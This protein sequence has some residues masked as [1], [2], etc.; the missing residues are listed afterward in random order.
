MDAPPGYRRHRSSSRR[1]HL[2]TGQFKKTVFILVFALAGSVALSLTLA[3]RYRIPPGLWRGNEDIRS[4]FPDIPLSGSLEMEPV[5][6]VL[7]A[8]EFGP[9]ADLFRR[10]QDD[11]RQKLR[12]LLGRPSSDPS[13]GVRSVRREKFN[14]IRRETLV[15]TQE[16]GLEVPAFLHRRDD[17]VVRPALLVIPGHSWGIVATSGIVDDY[18]NGN[19]LRLAAAGY[20]TLTME[21]RGFGY[22]QYFGVSDPPLT[23]STYTPLNLMRGKTSLGVT[24]QDQT[25]GLIYLASRSDV[26]RDQL[27]L[28]GFSSGCDTSVYLGALDPRV[29]ILVLS[30]CISSHESKFRY[31]QNDPY[32]AVPGLAL[33]LEMDDCL[34]LLSPRPALVQWGEL[35]DD[36]VSR[37]AAFNPT[38]LSTFDRAR[39]I[40]AGQNAAESLEKRISPAMHHEFDIVAAIEF[41]RRRMPPGDPPGLITE[42]RVEGSHP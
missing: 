2:V 8:P 24:I 5:R 1:G 25:A 30:G 6:P 4:T 10:W 16:D 9:S 41:L 20:V 14:G 28:V 17:E 15:F 40:Y 31:S 18:Q 34:G 42:V 21:V 7:A 26:R 39:R 38:A 23:R 13:F 12:E 36:P 33:W 22:L 11:G 37:H 35:D 27:G 3:L 19:A 32:Q 29:Q